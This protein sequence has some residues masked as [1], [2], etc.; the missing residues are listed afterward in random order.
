MKSQVP[1]CWILNDMKINKYNEIRNR[2]NIKGILSL[3]LRHPKILDAYS[4][5]YFLSQ[6]ETKYSIGIGSSNVFNDGDFKTWLENN[7]HL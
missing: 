6:M 1:K 2:E 3:L 4:D 7:N 5:P